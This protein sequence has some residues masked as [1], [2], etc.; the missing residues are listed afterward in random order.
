MSN[1]R[2]D[3]HLTLALQKYHQNLTFEQAV[4]FVH[5]GLPQC[6]VQAVDSSV[7]VLHQKHSSPFF[8]NAMTGG[9][10]SA[11]KINQQ[12]AQVAEATGLAMAT[13]SMSQALKDSMHA[14][15]YEIIRSTHPNGYLMANLGPDYTVQQAQ[16][17]V[18]LI[19]ANALQIHINAAQELVMPE[20]DRA[21]KQWLDRIEAIVHGV[22][23]PVIVKEVGF[24]MSYQT[25]DLLNQIGVHTID[26]SGA[27][28]TNFAQ[29][30]N[31][32]RRH[33]FQSNFNTWGIPT[34]LAL[35]EA[36]RIPNDRRPT[37]IASGGIQS[38]MDVVKAL[39][40]GA[41]WVG[42]SGYWLKFIHEHGVEQTIEEVNVWKEEIKHIMTLLSACTVNDLL[43]TDLVF[44]EATV[45][46][47]KQRH[48]PYKQFATRFQYTKRHE[49]MTRVDAYLIPDEEVDQYI[50]ERQY[51]TRKLELEARK[52]FPKVAIEFQGSEDGEALVAYSSS[53]QF[54]YLLSL[55]PLRI[56]ELK[57]ADLNGTWYDYLKEIV[58]LDLQPL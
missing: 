43:K 15:S 48:L 44:D 32:R 38:P 52:V 6:D 55:D 18:H 23:V 19:Q 24:G 31:A 1:S 25:I 37:I 35:L 8:I 56:R 29:I 12:L 46:W 58:G 41:Q 7:E 51:Y 4:R 40:M 42:I 47:A 11:F 30:E 34:P 14:K 16:E 20:G 57:E 28:G 49:H 39:A 36:S 2:K 26:I 45:N 3:D 13:G 50:N 54:H 5:H 21:F 27:G 53:G 9:S 17:A 10:D 22:S 33:H